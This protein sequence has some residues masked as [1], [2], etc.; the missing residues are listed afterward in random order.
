MQLSKWVLTAALAAAQTPPTIRVDVNLIQIDATVTGRDG[1]R[2][3][4]LKASDFEVQRDGKRQQLKSVL[5][6]PGQRVNQA[7]VTDAPASQSVTGDLRPEDVRR[8]IAIMIDDMS[9]SMSS[10]KSTRDA[11]KKLI[12]EH[13]DSRDLVAV[14]R[15]SG[16][17]GA[18]QQFTTNKRQLLAAVDGMN[19]GSMKVID[20]LA[21]VSMNPAETSGDPTIAAMALSSRFIEEVQNR[22]L[23][24][25]RTAAMLGSVNLA[26]R[27]LRELPGRK[28]MVL[29]SESIQLYDAP[30]SFNDPT[31]SAMAMK[32]GAQG[33]KRLRTETAMR[34]LVDSANRAGVLIYTIDPRGVVTTGIT[35][36]DDVGGGDPRRVA[37]LGSKRSFEFNLSRDGMTELAHETG[38]IFYGGSNDITGSLLTAL[39]DQEGYYLLAFQPDDATFEKSKN[40]AKFHR[41]SVKVNRPGAS[42]RYRRSFYGVPEA[43]QQKPTPLATALFSPF[44]AV[45]IPVKLTPLFMH[46]EKSGSFLRAMLHIDSSTLQFSEVPADAADTN[47]E[48]WQQALINEVVV[49]FDDTGRAVDQVGNPQKI[50]ARGPGLESLKKHGIDQQLDVPVPRPGAYQLRAAIFDRTSNLTGSA[51]QFVEVPDL[52]RKRLAL[53]GAVLSS[54]AWAED[55]DPAGS[56]AQRVL[57]KGGELEYALTVFNAVIPPDTK[58]PNLLTQ[59]RLF[60][61][62]T[63]LYTG[64]KVPLTAAAPAADELVM[65]KGRVRITSSP[66]EYVLEIGV[67]D[68]SAPAKQ[69]AAVRY[70]DFTVRD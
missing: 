52:K 15:T 11:V 9:L 23:Q 3:T 48:P 61:D 14:Y 70:V 56:A 63:L 24:D 36:A 26:V 5:W 58:R 69:Q 25:I 39:N 34:S 19:F 51:A 27:G 54:V 62:G 20:S 46:T 53:S 60:R 2:I 57:R 64:K 66:G 41:L 7:P 44:R 43:E 31:M 18:M 65:V 33:G 42:V 12:Q 17:I 1:K 40:G 13:V 21:P 38:G 68:Q 16:G 8:T 55:K 32:P 37:N 59:L 30:V 47:K 45:G 28:A 4:D 67:Q 10:M 49:L 6:V 22:E 50:K 29:F 35:A